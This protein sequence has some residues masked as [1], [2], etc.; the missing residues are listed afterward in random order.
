MSAD[1]N[2]NPDAPDEGASG[3]N[4]PNIKALREAAEAGK[5]AQAEAEAAKRELAL[6]KAGVD[7][8]SAVGKMFAKA[9][10]GDLDTEAIKAEWTQVAPT[11][12]PNDPPPPPEQVDPGEQLAQ[13]QQDR[14]AASGGQPGGQEKPTPNPIDAALSEFHDPARMGMQLEDRQEEAVAK[15]LGAYFEGDKRVMFDREAH[16]QRAMGHAADDVLS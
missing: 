9:Y 14:E 10:D 8:E 3:G 7:T 11:T 1:P 16:R 15:V 4:E 6:L 2:P 13:Q 5:A 12:S